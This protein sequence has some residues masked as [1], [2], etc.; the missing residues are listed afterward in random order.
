MMMRMMQRRIF[1]QKKITKHRIKLSPPLPSSSEKIDQY[2]FQ[3][4]KEVKIVDRCDN[5]TFSNHHHHRRSRLYRA[6]KKYH[7]GQQQL[8]V[9]C[10]LSSSFSWKKERNKPWVLEP[11]FP[12]L[13]FFS[14]C[15]RKE[16][17]PKKYKKI[18]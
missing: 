2:F 10:I 6:K 12:C 11:C 9:G 8:F 7:K 18:K 1:S 16:P 13:S 15:E 14:L 17:P 4:E 3:K 5:R